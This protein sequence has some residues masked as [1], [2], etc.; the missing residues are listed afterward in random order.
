MSPNVAEQGPGSV[1]GSKG[2]ARSPAIGLLSTES[3]VYGVILVAGLVEIL[4]SPA[5]AS[6]DVL[7]KV[8]VTVV[9]FW[10]AHLYAGTVAH[11]GD[12]HETDLPGRQRLALAARYALDHSWG[13]LI[14]PLLPVAF[15]LLGVVGVISD[16]VAIWGTL[17]IAVV[18]LGILGYLKAAAWTSRLSIRMTSAAVTSLLGLLLIGLKMLI[19]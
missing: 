6:W 17:W 10:L 9:V 7:V 2:W 16:E 5:V 8:L 15:L 1:D 3:A 4:S 12:E 14:A 13:M 18:V 11:L 19:H